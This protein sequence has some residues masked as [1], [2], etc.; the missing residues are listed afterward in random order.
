MTEHPRREVRFDPTPP[1][2]PH[3]PPMLVVKVGGSAG[4]D[5]A[6]V[7]ADLAALSTGGRRIVLVHGA[8]A[9]TDSLAA[10]LGHPSRTIVSPSGQQSRRTDRRTLEIFAMAALGVEMFRYVELLRSA[11]AHPLALFGALVGTRK[12]VRIVEDGRTILL[13]DDYT[14][15]INEIPVSLFWEVTGGGFLPVVPPLAISPQGEGLNI[16]GDRAAAAI[17]HSLRAETL[18]ILTN[19][20]GLLR[21]V[22]DPGSLV[23]SATI[24]EAEELA[25]GR[26]KK[27]TMAARE[28]IENGVARVVI[29]SAR[30]DRPISRALAGEGTVIGEAVAA[31]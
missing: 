4:V 5:R 8:S 14:G 6:A 31:R 19:V 17:A 23:T 24:E 21:S 27:K 30:V 7:A 16:D 13:R 20:P 25:H 2:P 10:S 3:F 1:P 28:A 29:A 15:R 26:M 12:D 9:E 18:V 22:D 11:G